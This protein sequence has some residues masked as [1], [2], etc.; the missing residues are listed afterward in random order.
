MTLHSAFAASIEYHIDSWTTEN[1]L[2]QNV[3]RDICQTPDGIRIESE[4]S[5]FLI[6][7][8]QTQDGFGFKFGNDFACVA[9]SRKLVSLRSH[10]GNKVCPIDQDVATPWKSVDC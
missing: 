6:R 2:P 1:G 3:I 7:P 10:P 4:N 9:F 5:S 8:F